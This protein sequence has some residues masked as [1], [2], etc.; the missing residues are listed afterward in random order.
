MEGNSASVNAQVNKELIIKATNGQLKEAYKRIES[1]HAT[2]KK[3]HDKL[4][5]AYKVINTTKKHMAELQHAI[6]YLTAR[7]QTDI[8][9]FQT[10]T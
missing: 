8:K 5:A 7:R 10:G 1:L 3:L 4:K 9:W 6:A 2:G